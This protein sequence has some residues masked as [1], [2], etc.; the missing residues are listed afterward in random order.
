MELY[1]SFDT[2]TSEGSVAV[3]TRAEALAERTLGLRDEHSA[4]LVPAIAAVLAEVGKGPRDLTGVVVASGPGSFTGVRVAA[5]TAKGLVAS[6]GVP[7]YGFSSL[8][9]AAVAV[10]AA[11]ARGPVGKGADAAVGSRRDLENLV[12]AQS[13]VCSVFDA[14]GDRVYGG[15]YR[16]WRGGLETILR[17]CATTI[18]E[19]LHAVE[20]TGAV[21]AGQGAWRHREQIAAAGGRVV[22][23]PAAVPSATALLWL[24][25]L[26]PG[27]ARI[28]EPGRWEPDYL[29]ASTVQV[30]GGR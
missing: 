24:L 6:L 20:P 9:A 30:S 8:A 17:P 28:G 2:S 29:R 1:L 25:A 21:F 11:A 10:G 19:L 18:G 4:R 7:L 27:D 15:C 16:I 13:V 5:A 12:S 22:S 26:G 14:R 23:P 3:G